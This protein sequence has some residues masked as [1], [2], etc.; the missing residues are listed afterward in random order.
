MGAQYLLTDGRNLMKSLNFDLIK[1]L[2][3]PQAV[4]NILKN[5][6]LIELYP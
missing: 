5:T 3:N 6:K 2:S 1:D 4:G